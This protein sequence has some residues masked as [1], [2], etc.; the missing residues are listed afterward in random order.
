[1]VFPPLIAECGGVSC[2]QADR[3]QLLYCKQDLYTPGAH[4]ALFMRRRISGGETGGLQ[5]ACAFSSHMLGSCEG[6]RRGWR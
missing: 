5:W 3:M 1:M 6:G 2:A 4:T